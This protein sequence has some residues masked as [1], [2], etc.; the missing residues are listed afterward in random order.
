MRLAVNWSPQA[1][2]LVREGRIDVDL[3]KCTDWPELVEPALKTKPAYVHFP[4]RAGDGSLPDWAAVRAWM[5]KTGTQLVN[6][7]LNV[8][9]NDMPDIPYNS[10]SSEHR[11]RVIDA[12]VRDVRAAGD[13]MEMERIMVE[14]LPT[15]AHDDG[16]HPLHVCVDPETICAVIERTNCMLLLDIDHARA[17]AEVLGMDPHAYIEALPIDRIGEFHMTGTRREHGKLEGHRPFTSDDWKYFDWA[18]ERFRS[19]AWK[20]PD[21]YA[22]E[23]GGIGPGFLEHTDSAVLAEQVPILLEKV[24]SLNT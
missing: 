19:G 21:T 18:I 9:T 13:A 14:N 23:Y 17:S 22:F 15:F 3:W 12:L 4:I 5:N 6:M 8:N 24:R 11:E 7:H 16:F 2:Q 1:D 20:T 10:L